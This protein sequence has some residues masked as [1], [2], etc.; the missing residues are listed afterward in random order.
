MRAMMT[1]LALLAAMALGACTERTARISVATGLVGGGIGLVAGALVGHPVEGA[2][3]GVVLGAA[4]GAFAGTL[5]EVVHDRNEPR[6]NRR[7]D[8]RYS[9]RRYDGRRTDTRYGYRY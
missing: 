8:R 4:T 9:G 2:R 5:E 3:R 1:A 6:G 7:L